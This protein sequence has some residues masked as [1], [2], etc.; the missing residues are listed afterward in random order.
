MAL[1]G[2]EIRPDAEDIW[3]GLDWYEFKSAAQAPTVDAN[4]S[5]N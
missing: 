3:H 5:I 4:N 1:E 2:V